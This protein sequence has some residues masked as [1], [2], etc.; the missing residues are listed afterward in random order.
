MKQSLNS[1]CVLKLSIKRNESKMP[2]LLFPS[3]APKIRRKEA[4]VS[5]LGQ[6]S[7][8]FRRVE[9]GEAASTH[10]SRAG[11]G[12]GQGRPPLDKPTAAER[13]HWLP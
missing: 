13:D 11:A 10:R 2:S 5:G 9:L 7:S 6:S 12:Q 1:K 8:G 4:E 3:V